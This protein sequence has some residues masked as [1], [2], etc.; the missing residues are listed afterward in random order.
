MVVLLVLL[1]VLWL[2]MSPAPNGERPA[3]Q[4]GHGPWTFVLILLLIVLV[5]AG[6]V[7]FFWAVNAW[8]AAKKRPIHL[9][10]LFT[11]LVA[12]CALAG[13]VVWWAGQG[14]VATPFLILAAVLA[15]Q[16]H[17][18]S[19][20]WYHFRTGVYLTNLERYAEAEGHLQKAWRRAT[21]YSAN[22]FRRGNILLMLGEWHRLQLLL[23]KAEEYFQLALPV[24]QEHEQ[25]HFVELLTAYN[26][27]G[28]VYSDRGKYV[29]AEVYF[30]QAHSLACQ[31]LPRNGALVALTEQNIAGPLLELEDYT[32]AEGLLQSAE[33]KTRRAD[34][35]LMTM[36]KL[37]K[38]YLRTNNLA[39]AEACAREALPVLQKSLHVPAPILVA[40]LVAATEISRRQ[41]KLDEAEQQAAQALEI[42]EKFRTKS[43]SSQVLALTNMAAIHAAKDRL[44]D[45]ERLFR[46]ALVVH[47]E[48]R[49]PNNLDWAE[50]LEQFADVLRR[51]GM[52]TEATTWQDRAQDVRRHWRE[53]Q[54]AP[55]F[56]DERI[57]VQP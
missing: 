10:W 23:D 15:F 54:A 9:H 50:S 44:A 32:Q 13:G 34:I 57:K 48:S 12:A 4:E 24:L 36:A 14:L 37:A 17:V 31:R 43:P 21:R 5:P 51:T 46:Q 20:F 52:D 40:V 11:A 27:L 55:R 19:P 8:F 35:W 3:G 53:R 26:N 22:D 49:L 39:R 56:R 28:V 2:T 30:R 16:L 47:E 1:F 18:F 6:V 29:E 42:A 7:G 38:L 41:G 25:Q 45:A 33:R